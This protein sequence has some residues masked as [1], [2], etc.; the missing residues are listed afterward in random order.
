VYI[1]LLISGIG[2]INNRYLFGSYFSRAGS[3]GNCRGAR[4]HLCQKEPHAAVMALL[5]IMLSQVGLVYALLSV[6]IIIVAR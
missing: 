5:A 4:G 6:P 3:W 2:R 1:L